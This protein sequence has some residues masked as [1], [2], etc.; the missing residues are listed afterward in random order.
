M[1]ISDHWHQILGTCGEQL[2]SA[3]T[4]CNAFALETDNGLVLFD[5][6]AG[7]HAAVQTR[8]F[9]A[10]GFPGGP[11]H[12]FLTHAHADHAGGA[13]DIK[14]RYGAT[15]YAGPLTA[16]WLGAAD[17]AKVSLPAARRAGVYPQSYVYR[18]AETDRI[19]HQGA[20][21]S[22]GGVE[23]RA[24][25]TPGH[26]ADHFSYLV[27]KGGITTLIAGDAIFSGGKVVLQ[28]TWDCSVAQTC[29]TIRSLFALDF[30]AL[31]AGHGPFVLDNGKAHVAAAMERVDSLLPPL[32]LL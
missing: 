31:F 11:T 17:E 32:N 21:L 9:A 12:M 26:S 30:N 28:D 18:A 5:A 16:Q 2:L 6:G 25:T 10:A 1:R 15:L 22:I 24:L 23:I 19:V 8:A 7:Q 29:Q 27:R 3:A 20:V 14:E 13:A 4:D